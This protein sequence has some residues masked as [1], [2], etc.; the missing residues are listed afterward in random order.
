MISDFKPILFNTDENFHEIEIY[1][2]HDIHRGSEIHDEK[3]WERFKAEILS[4]PNRFVIWAGDYSENAITGSKGDVYSQD[5]MP[6]EQKW[7][8]TNELKQLKD[9]TICIVPGNHENNRITKNVGLYPA[10]DC[11]LAAGIEDRYRQHFAFVDIGV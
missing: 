11:A 6:A 9:R 5:Y 3:K 7:W 10:Y 2:A 8:F 1:F 4:A